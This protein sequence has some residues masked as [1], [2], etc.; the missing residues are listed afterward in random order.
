MFVLAGV[1]ADVDLIAG[2]HS[3][4][5]HSVGGALIALALAFFWPAGPGVRRRS[6]RHVVMAVAV[7]AAYLTH[8]LL[9]WLGQDNNPPIGVML[10]WP[11]SSRYFH[12]GF[13]WFY[14]I[15]RRYWLPDFWTF[16]LRSVARE[17][18]L[19]APPAAAVLAFRRPGGRLS[20]R[21]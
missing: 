9:D 7:G 15:S 20:R 19:L 21:P 8:P 18:L 4:W 2:A 16:N 3:G 6:W 11:L 13:D 5:T 10:L 12:S 14:A 17:I 1:V